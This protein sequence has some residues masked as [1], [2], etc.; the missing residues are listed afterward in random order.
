MAGKKSL[1]ILFVTSEV[2]P[3]MKTGGLADVS[4]ALPQRLLQHG[5]Q[6]RILAPKYGA[7][8]ERKHKIHE[9]VRLKDLTTQIGK[10]EVTFSIRSSFL[11]GQKHRVQ[12]YFLDEPNYFASRH[13]LYT[14][15]LTGKD[16]P[17]NDERFILLAKS[18]FEL[19]KTLGWY[20][21]IIHCNDW[22]SALIPAYL[23]TLY[24]DDED[25]QNIKTLFTIHNI[26]YQGSFGKTTCKKAGFP[27]SLCKETKL[28]HKGR[29]NFLKE[30]ILYADA[31]NTVSETY[32]KEI[33]SDA[34]VSF[35]MVDVL[36]KRKANLHGIV[37][38]IDMNIWN[39]EKDKLIPQKYSIKKLDKKKVNRQALAEKLQVE[40]DDKTPIIGNIS[41]LYD[42]KG[43]DLIKKAF[44]K[45]MAM[46]VKF[47]IL[48]TGDKNLHRFL[49][50][51]AFDYKDKF[52]FYPGFDD[53]LAHLIEA[54]AD[55]YLMPSK[56]EPC[57]LNQM[58][59]MI[60]GTVPIVHAT[61]GLVDTV[62]N[63]DMKT[64]EGTGFIFEKYN[65]TSLLTEIKRAV[66]IFKDAP[67]TWNKIVKN[68]MKQDFSWLNSAKNYISLYNEIISD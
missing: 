19:V 45:L 4:A 32:A 46:D 37:N 20:P 34:K 35:G 3:F 65:V 41:R 42:I 13:S 55:M 21:D 57:G 12:V 63:F 14:N 25:I 6:V 59:S 43:F 64:G 7:I 15:P 2:I 22:Q 9:V 18:V 16:F 66:T 24:K 40:I 50:E 58:Y 60:Y 48:G 61:G 54:G 23:K 62:K 10:K 44:P 36:K 31:I 68:G 26:A 11:P 33:A 1:K 5:H 52:F 17:D 38:G 30:G 67:E 39:P 49:E 56:T 8:D 51:A 29:F 53:K 28:L 47:V 27:E